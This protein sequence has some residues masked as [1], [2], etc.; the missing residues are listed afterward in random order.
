MKIACFSFT[1]KGEEIGD[2][3]LDC[4]KEKSKFIKEVGHFKN[5]S[6]DGGI[7]KIL[8]IIV[9]KYNGIVFIS[10][11]GIAIRLMMPFIKN[12]KI[13]PAVVVV[14]DLGRYSISLLSGHIG[15]GN[16]LAKEIGNIID[17]KPI[18]TTASDSR[19]IESVDIYAMRNNLYMENM[20]SIKNITALMVEERKI[21]FYSEIN[22]IID[23]ENLVEVENKEEIHLIE[24]KVDGFL[25]VTS[26]EYIE[27]NIPHTIL[28]PKNLNIGIGCRRGVKGEQIIKSIIDLFRKNNLSKKSIK[29]IGTIS[30]KKDEKG[31]IEAS[32]YFNCPINIYSKEEIKEVE[33]KFKKNKFVKEKIGVY[34]VSEPSAYLS[35][36]RL[37]INKTIYKDITLAVSKEEI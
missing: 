36:G 14:D 26:E 9:N 33:D 23:Y 19:G 30:L 27:I 22:T 11:T 32:K 10:A 16:I 28:R 37:I 25:I 29:S 18:I 7:K 4:Y 35:G 2:K 15:G 8:P 5:S 24:K 12:K 34:G 17:A 31:I 20:N 3:I 13:D 1:T 6:I 21:G